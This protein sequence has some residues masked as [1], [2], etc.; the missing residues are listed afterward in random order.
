MSDEIIEALMND[1]EEQDDDDYYEI[2]TDNFPNNSNN[3]DNENQALLYDSTIIREEII[4]NREF[5][6]KEKTCLILLSYIIQLILFFLSI[7]FLSD[8][9]NQL[10]PTTISIIL[11]ISIFIIACIT[12]IIAFNFFLGQISLNLPIF[13]LI[14]IVSISSLSMFFILYKL[15]IFWTFHYFAMVTFVAIIIYLTLIFVNF[16]NKNPN[17]LKMEELISLL[18][19]CL[20][21]FILFF[22]SGH[23][24]RIVIIDI[25]FGNFFFGF[26]SKLH[27]NFLVENR[28]YDY[29]SI[30][31]SF[32]LDILAGVV[33]YFLFFMDYIS[34]NEQY[35]RIK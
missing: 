15:S 8:Y 27:L 21:I 32:Y 19:I 28:I 17:E 11:F 22:I 31:I 23:K 26:F 20:L 33:M 9:I 6:D 34:Q 12:V 4:N 16:F 10:N 7:Y 2:S 25:L 30:H 13:I 35:S 14:I 18:V 1:I 5:T 24:N 3:N 29:L